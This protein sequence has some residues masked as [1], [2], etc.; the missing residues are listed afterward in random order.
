MLK[1]LAGCV[2]GSLIVLLIWVISS[3]GVLFGNRISNPDIDLSAISASAK[4]KPDPPN[5]NKQDRS[6]TFFSKKL[7][8]QVKRATPIS[9]PNPKQTK[10]LISDTKQ[11]AESNCVIIDGWQLSSKP[12]QQS[13]SVSVPIFEPYATILGRSGKKLRVK[14]SSCITQVVKAHSRLESETKDSAWAEHMETF[15]RDFLLGHTMV[16]AYFKINIVEC[17]TTLCELQLEYENISSNM[18]AKFLLAAWRD[19]R[20]DMSQQYW[21]NE[22][23]PSSDAVLAQRI[24]KDDKQVF[25]ILS[26]DK[27]RHIYL[28]SLDG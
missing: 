5:T 9:I 16:S 23:S 18:S 24:Y 12:R 6:D 1:F 28:D 2:S 26:I 7:S 8:E 21:W 17:R 3:N 22:V 14:P 15:Y 20:R 10:T 19:I 13:T 25:K 27:R 4:K 11:Y